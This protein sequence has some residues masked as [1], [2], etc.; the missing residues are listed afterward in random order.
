MGGENWRSKQG[1]AA[2]EEVK[3]ARL[4]DNDRGS[5]EQRRKR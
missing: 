1:A 2:S 4:I 3:E 5:R